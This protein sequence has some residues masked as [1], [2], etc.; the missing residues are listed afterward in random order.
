MAW[1]LAIIGKAKDYQDETGK[2]N[3]DFV[4]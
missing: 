1:F 4:S 3:S 2:D